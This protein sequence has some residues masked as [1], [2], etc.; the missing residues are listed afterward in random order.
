MK[1][2]NKEYIEHLRQKY[3]LGT[4][5]QLG[6]MEDEMAVPPGSMGTVDF[7]DD[8]D[9]WTLCNFHWIFC[10]VLH[11][12]FI[13]Q[14]YILVLIGSIKQPLYNSPIIRIVQCV[15]DNLYEII[16]SLISYII[17]TS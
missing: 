2:P 15:T 4:R 8:E 13:I 6:C 10:C 11:K 14:N 7:I 12:M 1:Y 17:N 5:L 9:V 3:P 16:K